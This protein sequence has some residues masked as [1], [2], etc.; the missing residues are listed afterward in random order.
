MD[1]SRSRLVLWSLSCL[2]RG[3]ERKKISC[4]YFVDQFRAEFEIC[5][6]F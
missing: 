1:R 4:R 6:F 3:K 2:D 5:P